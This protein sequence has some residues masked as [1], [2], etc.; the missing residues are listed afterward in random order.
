MG[1]REDILN[2]IESTLADI[3]IANGYNNNIGLVTRESEDF[4]RFEK[5]DYPFAIISWATDDKETSG[6]P[7]QNV[8]SE[9]LVTIMGGIYA[10]SSRETVLN[11]FLDDIEKALCT[12]GTRGNNAWYTIP[13][14]IEVMFTSKQN[15]IVF[16]YRFLIRY[17]YVY[18]NP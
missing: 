5:S 15:V 7:N 11:N 4:E 13:V 3:T 17:H 2:N 10:I 18:G 9:L 8:I 12:D 6:V 1:K 14:G 16:N